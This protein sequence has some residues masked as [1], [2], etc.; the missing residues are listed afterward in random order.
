MMKQ[1]TFDA[2]IITLK[3]LSCIYR[4]RERAGASLI[5]SILYGSS[6]KKIKESSFDKLTT[7]GIVKDFNEKQ[8]IAII[9]YLMHL[10]LLKR[11]FRYKTLVLTEKGKI[12]LKEK[13]V[14]NLPATLLPQ[15]PS[16]SNLKTLALWQQGLTLPAISQQ[17]NL[18]PSTIEN[19]IADLVRN[20]KI[21]DVSKL[22]SPEDLKLINDVLTANNGYGLRNIK[23]QLPA[24]IS[25]GQ[26]K[27]ALAL[28]TKQG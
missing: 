8:I 5:A 21:T 4:A 26:I 22:V 24:H 3:I 25:Y 16:P 1:D 14:L 19:H 7:F 18:A 6:R 10:G 17:R 28:K 2:S 27:I 15:Q 20:H 13:P 9:H 23:S 11:S 12:F